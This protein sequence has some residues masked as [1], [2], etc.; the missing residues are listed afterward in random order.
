MLKGFAGVYPIPDDKK[1]TDSAKLADVLEIDSVLDQL[2]AYHSR[3]GRS[4]ALI[5]VC[6]QLSVARAIRW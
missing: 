5:R 6:R 2:A 4:V 3:C 1:V